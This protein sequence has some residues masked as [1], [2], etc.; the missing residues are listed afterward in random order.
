MVFVDATISNK[1]GQVVVGAI[2]K[3][4]DGQYIVR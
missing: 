2:T 1:D 4:F 3:K